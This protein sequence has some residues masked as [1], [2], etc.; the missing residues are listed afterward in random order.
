M[1]KLYGY[2]LST[3]YHFE[4]KREIESLHLDV[5]HVQQEFTVGIFGR[6]LAHNLHIPVV[7]TYHTLYEDYTH[8]VNVFDLNS[9]EKISRKAFIRFRECFAIRFPASLRPVRKLRKN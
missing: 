9:V 2:T 4:V 7:Y 3:P 5:I 8:Y 1:K 6:I